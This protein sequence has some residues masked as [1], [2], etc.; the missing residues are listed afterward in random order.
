[1]P[2]QLP[3]PRPRQPSVE[4]DSARCRQRDSQMPAT[5]TFRIAGASK[6]SNLLF[7]GVSKSG[8][9]PLGGVSPEPVYT[10]ASYEA[11]AA[12][13][14]RP[15]ALPPKKS[16]SSVKNGSEEVARRFSG[17]T[18]GGGTLGALEAAKTSRASHPVAAR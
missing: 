15:A 7:A 16:T 12:A 17:A 14:P 2:R 18:V 6:S 13:E 9:L 3:A 5:C 8:K 1:V 4:P 10:D 11:S